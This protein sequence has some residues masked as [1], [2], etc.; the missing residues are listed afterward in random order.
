MENAGVYII[1]LSNNDIGRKGIQ[2]EKTKSQ[3]QN[4]PEVCLS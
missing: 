2:F 3:C 1:H 4:T